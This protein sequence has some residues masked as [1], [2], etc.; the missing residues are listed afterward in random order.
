MMVFD[1]VL[2]S[3]LKLPCGS[4]EERFPEWVNE[5]EVNY[6]DALLPKWEMDVAASSLSLESLKVPAV[7]GG[8]CR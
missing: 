1:K 3:V 6:I 5:Y 2:N 4:K 7:S 8:D